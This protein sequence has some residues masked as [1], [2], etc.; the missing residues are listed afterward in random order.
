MLIKFNNKKEAVIKT[1][2]KSNIENTYHKFDKD[3]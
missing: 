3:N 2:H 1:K